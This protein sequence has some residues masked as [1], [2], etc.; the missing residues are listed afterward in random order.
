MADDCIPAGPLDQDPGGFIPSAEQEALLLEVLAGVE[1]G[2][3]DRRII[4]WLA[5]CDAST[6][7]PVASLIQRARRAELGRLRAAAV[8]VSAPVPVNLEELPDAWQPFAQAMEA[9]RE[10]LYLDNGEGGGW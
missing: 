6:L 2:A 4:Y 9:L 7:R 1:L 10:A 5:G 3:F 8:G